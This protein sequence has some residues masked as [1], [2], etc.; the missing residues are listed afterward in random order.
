[1]GR[2]ATHK[3]GY[4]MLLAVCTHSLPWDHQPLTEVLTQSRGCCCVVSCAFPAWAP[5][6]GSLTGIPSFRVPV[7]RGR[8]SLVLGSLEMWA[9]K[10]PRELGAMLIPL[11]HA[12]PAG[13]GLPH[14]SYLLWSLTHPLSQIPACR[15]ALEASQWLCMLKIHAC[16]AESL[17]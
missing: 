4:A 8:G 17:G 7:E 11:W 1:M 12:E 10:S 14:L 3:P 2:G 16:T 6:T 15:Q 9:Q 13:L 5:C